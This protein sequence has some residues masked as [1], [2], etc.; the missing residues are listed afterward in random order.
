MM[1]VT[2]EDPSPETAANISNALANRLRDQIADIMN[3]DKPSLVERAVPPT[4][5]SSPSTT[6]NALIGGLIGALIVIIVLIP[7]AFPYT[8]KKCVNVVYYPHDS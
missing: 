3:T 7:F 6:R 8:F 2:A 1:Q 5:K 4:K